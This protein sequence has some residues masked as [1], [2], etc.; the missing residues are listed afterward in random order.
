M[1]SSPAFH[2]FKSGKLT[3]LSLI[4]SVG[5]TPAKDI[6]ES[7]EEHTR[8]MDNVDISI[9]KTKM[10]ISPCDLSGTCHLSTDYVSK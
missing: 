2:H 4:V 5:C 7:F 9:E 6:V 3:L 1:T 10:S 8:R